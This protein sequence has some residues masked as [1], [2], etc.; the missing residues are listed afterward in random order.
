[1]VQLKNFCFECG[2][3]VAVTIE[4]T[5]F[6]LQLKWYESSQCLFCNSASEADGVGFA[7]EEIREA[8]LKAEGKWRLV[9]VSMKLS[10][11]VKLFKVIR[12][13]LNLSIKEVSTLQNT[14]PNMASGTKTEMQWLQ[15]LLLHEEIISSIEKAD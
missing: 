2:N 8:I 12:Q 5:V 9:V 7:P 3:T 14:F 13:S 4:Q 11:K 1:M 10:D 15:K 6:G